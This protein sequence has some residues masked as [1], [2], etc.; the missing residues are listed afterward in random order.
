MNILLQLIKKIKSN[1]ASDKLSLDDKSLFLASIFTI[2]GCMFFSIVFWIAGVGASHIILTLAMMMFFMMSLYCLAR[3]E[4]YSYYKHFMV[5]VV[6]FLLFPTFFYVTG[7]IYNGA[8]LFFPLGIIITFFIIRSRVVYLWG[9]V[10]ILW[11]CLVLLLPVLDYEKFAPYRDSQPSLGIGIVVCFVG[12][13]SAPIL[14][15]LYQTSV[16]NRIHDKLIDSNKMMNEA[17][18]NKSRFLANL[19]HEI[20]MPMNAI[21]SMNELM[22]RENLDAESRE[23]AEEI[24]SSSNQLLKIVNNILEFSKLDS[25]RMELYPRQYDFKEMISDII[26]TVSAEY[27]SDDNEF[28]VEIDPDIPRSLFGDNVRMKQVFM[29]LLFSAVNKFP[30]NRILLSIKSEIDRTTNTVLLTCSIAESGLGLSDVEIEAMLSAYT[31]YDSRQKSDYKAM[32]LELSICKEILNMMGGNLTIDSVE[33]V[34]IRI[35][36]DFINYIIE[37]MPIARVSPI[38]DYSVLVYC[39]D[40]YDKDIWTNILMPFQMYPTVVN[41]PNAFRNAIENR[42]Y[43]HIFID[44]TFYSMLK[45]TIRDADIENCVYIV[46]EAGS[47]YS[48]YG[49]CKILRKP[50]NCINVTSALND[51][52]TAENYK[53]AAKREMVTYPEA[54][55]LIVDDSVVNLKV[56]EGMLATFKINVQKAKSGKA[57]LDIMQDEEFDLLILDQRMPEMD[58]I[59]LFGRIKMLGN[60]NS[61]VPILCA[62]ADFG[63]EVARYLKDVGFSDYLAKPVRRF[64]LERM[65]RQYI[66]VELAVNVKVDEKEENNVDSTKKDNNQEVVQNEDPQVINYEEGKSIVDGDRKSVV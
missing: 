1:I 45:D 61:L 3:F 34:G 18:F 2:P 55:V 5:L 17:Q 28:Y 65:L 23:L 50:L 46:T 56:L 27:A 20:R 29:Y 38:K 40:S 47:V 21:V 62:T 30:H 14:I 52:W 48:D 19:T 42:K 10:E 7:D 66:P 49:K 25:N 44:S 53:I 63:P 8:V 13:V 26:S 24:R 59:E 16:Y 43:T 31:R 6:S 64:Y 35:K 39:N 32:G 4:E 9:V 36:F 22:L 58:G 11:Y 15:I 12:A 54:K 41:G 37:E 33:G 51:D 57:A 60:A